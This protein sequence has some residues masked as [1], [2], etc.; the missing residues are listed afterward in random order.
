MVIDTLSFA[1]SAQVL[2]GQL[3]AAACERLCQGLPAQQPGVFQWRIVGRTDAGRSSAARAWLDVQA[4]GCVRVV[5]QRCLAP[6]DLPLDVSNTLALVR[7][8]AQL[9]AMDAQEAEGQ[10]PETEYMV[11]DPHLDVLALIED[12]LILALPYAP[13]HETCPGTDG[14]DAAPEDGSSQ[15]PSPFAALAQLR[16][17]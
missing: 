12:E 9:E 10:G 2:D 4:H 16:K 15:R 17:H 5:C 13:R 8:T 1:R 6:F 11:A 3:P 7:D 14:A